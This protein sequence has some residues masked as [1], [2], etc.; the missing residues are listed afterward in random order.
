MIEDIEHERY[1]VIIGAYDMQAV[2]KGRQR[3][4]WSTRVSIRA[5]GN[6]FDEWLPAMF[7]NAANH[8][9]EESGRLIRRY[10]RAARVE[11]G[12]LKSLGIVDDAAMT[13]R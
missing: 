2:L 7:A 11:L 12:E 6:R 4:L 3:L 1:Y 9:G 5:Q 13:S 10:Q 8:F